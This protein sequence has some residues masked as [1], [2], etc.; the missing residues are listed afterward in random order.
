MIGITFGAFDLTHA[1]HYTMFRECKKYCDWLI[2]AIQTDPSI[3]RPKKNKPI[4]SILERQ[5]QVGSC[6][7]VNDTIVYETE[8]DLERI[9]QTLDLDVRI[10]GI[11]HKDGFFTGREICEKRGIKICYNT[12]DH[13]YSTSDL[14][15]RVKNGI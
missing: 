15:K 13:D 6:K 9:L 5:I 7:W 10:V 14:R 4:Q 12:R 1:G 11:D 8:K 2:V 3:D